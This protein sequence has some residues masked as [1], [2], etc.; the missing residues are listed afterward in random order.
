MRM[1]G[2]MDHAGRRGRTTRIGGAAGLAELPRSC[3]EIAVEMARIAATPGSISE[4]AEELLAPLRRIVPFEAARIAL[5]DPESRRHVLLTCRGYD[6]RIRAFMTTPADFAEIEQVGL[7]RTARPML[8]RD[9]PVPVAEVPSWMEL[10][11][12]AGFREGLGVGLFTP[13]GRH[14]GLLGL[15]TDTVAHPTTA[16]R[17]LIGALA[18]IIAAAVDPIATIAAAARLVRQAHSGIVLTRHGN[19]LPLPGLPAHP[20]LQ[21]GSAVLQEATRLLADG[22]CYVSFLSPYRDEHANGHA[23]ITVLS[24]RPHAD[25]YLAGLVMISP[26]PDLHHLTPIDLRI[27]GMLTEDWAIQRV[28]AALDVS[29]RALAGQ[30]EHILLKIGAPSP[31]VAV[32]RAVREG[33][34]LPPALAKP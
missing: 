15:N 31:D 33:L 13:D 18:P 14:L 16:A 26:P 22:A 25:Y 1:S 21:P 28:A 17:D 27:L 29:T 12:P 20:L 2:W 19:P 9:L 6:D 30:L 5:I 32:V 24:C 34:H 10:F 8:L 23:Q 7:H 11:Q 3:G 4:R